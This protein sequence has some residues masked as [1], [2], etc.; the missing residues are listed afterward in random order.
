MKV[1]IAPA[2]W[3][4]ACSLYFYSYWNWKYFVLI[5]SS[6]LV[7]YYISL[8]LHSKISGYAKKAF[9]YLAIIFNLGLIGYYKYANFFIDNVNA[10]AQTNFVFQQ[11][12]LPLGISFFTFQE[13]TFIVDTYKGRAPKY[14]LLNYIVYIS[15]FPQLIAGPI[16]HHNELM[17]QLNEYKNI[18]YGNLAV[19][20]TVFALGLFKKIMFADYCG[21]IA[22]PIYNGVTNGYGVTTPEAW[23]ACISYTLQLYFDFSGYSDMALGLAFMLGINLPINFD[24]P[25][26]AKSII[27]FWRRWHIT[28]S[29]FLRDYIYIPLGGNRSGAIRKHS[30]LLMTMLIGGLWHGAAWTFVAWGGLHGIYLVIN[31]IWIRFLEKSGMTGLRGNFFYKI[32]ALTLTFTAVALTWVLFR[33]ETFSCAKDI[34]T[35]MFIPTDAEETTRYFD[36]HAILPFGINAGLPFHRFILICLVLVCVL[37]PN[38]PA[39]FAKL[40][41]Y[42]A[43]GF[44]LNF[45]LGAAIFL[46]IFLSLVLI[47]RSGS[48]DFIYFNF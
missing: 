13:L 6:I 23:D 20:V 31:N 32:A 36:N 30:N 37:M 44:K 4:A 45:C 3:I 21:E 16:V 33:A 28:L 8:F 34:I 48:S 17:P 41:R 11:I 9:F 25:Y 26:K 29:R 24:S 46:I 5:M 27:E 42:N 18:S 22:N 14:T 15:F 7:N 38:I 2:L 35:A 39:M 43:D 12:I 47:G 40:K 10:V 1:A 19:G